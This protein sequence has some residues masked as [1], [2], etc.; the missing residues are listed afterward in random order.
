ME[1]KV[2][3][4]FE[5]LPIKCKVDMGRQNFIKFR[6]DLA[7]AKLWDDRPLKTK[8]ILLLSWDKNK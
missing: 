8:V 4:K 7:S 6:G 2:L 5:Y 1:Q 3:E